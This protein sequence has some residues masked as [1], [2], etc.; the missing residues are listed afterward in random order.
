VEYFAGLGHACPAETNPAEFLIDLVTVDNEDPEKGARDRGRIDGL[1]AT[2]SREV[3]AREASGPAE[4]WTPPTGAAT[5]RRR[6]GRR[7]FAR[8]FA[9]LLRR[10]WRQNARDSRLNLLRLA[11]SAGQGVLFAELFKSVRRGKSVARSV[12]DRVALLSFGAINVCMLAVMKTLDL[13][14]KEKPVV[15]R[16]RMRRQY[17]GLE[18]L[19]SKALAEL[20]LDACFGAAFAAVLKARTGLRAS[21]P[22][23][24]GTFSLLTVAGAALGFA[25]GSVA[26]DAESSLALGVPL[27]VILL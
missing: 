15:T 25:V 5:P 19:L 24:A 17:G 12:A 20:P 10:A 1:V 16:E 3:A 11:G 7:R 26:P 8:R 23:L 6:G 4:L 21:L 2:F 14:A 9:V 22:V 18:Y 13:F 27:M